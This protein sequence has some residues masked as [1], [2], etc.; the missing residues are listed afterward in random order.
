MRFFW[1][2]EGIQKTEYRI[3]TYRSHNRSWVAMNGKDRT[4]GWAG[5]SL[6][7]HRQLTFAHSVFCILYSVFCILYSVLPLRLALN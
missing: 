3:Q 7:E 5:P 1:E 6:M 4:T 2:E